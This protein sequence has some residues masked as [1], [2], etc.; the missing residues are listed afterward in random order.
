MHANPADSP[1]DSWHLLPLLDI[2]QTQRLNLGIV[3]T[4]AF[5]TD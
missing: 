1:L 4:L 2:G 3:G 5:L